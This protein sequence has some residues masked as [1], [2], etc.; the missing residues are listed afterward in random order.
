M[1]LPWPLVQQS[2]LAD[3]NVVED[4]QLGIELTLAGKPPLFLPEARVDSPLPQQRAAARNQRTRWEH[5]HL[6]TLLTQAP[7][8]IHLAIEHRRLD[9]FWLAL[10]LAIPPLSLLVIAL[11]AATVTAGF[12]FLLGATVW[13]LAMLLGACMLLEAAV[14]AGWSAFCREQIPLS[15]LFAALPL[16]LGGG[17]GSELRNP[18]GLTMVGGLIVSQMLTL[19]TTPVIYLWFDRLS[20]RR[21]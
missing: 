19:F 20:R 16:M 17:V 6:Q 2:K 11:T 8:L 13:P 5:G 14:L 3:G 18:L 1:A 12:A 7:R 10:D 15:A 21:A 4:M 9:L